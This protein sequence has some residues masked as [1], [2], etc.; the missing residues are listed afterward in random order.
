MFFSTDKKKFFTK[1]NETSHKYI[2]DYKQKH[3]RP[4]KRVWAFFLMLKKDIN[5]ILL[6][7][8]TLMLKLWYFAVLLDIILKCSL[9]IM[10]LIIYFLLNH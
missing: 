3:M 10:T 8:Y 2:T 7:Y 6:K 4:R 1:H 9:F 5:L